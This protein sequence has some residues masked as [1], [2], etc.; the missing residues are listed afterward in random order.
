MLIKN[1]KSRLHDYVSGIFF[2]S[3]GGGI[4]DEYQES[5]IFR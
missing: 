4:I 5:V 3:A 1:R 2:C